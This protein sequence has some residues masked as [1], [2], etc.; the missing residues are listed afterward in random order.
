MRI[1]MREICHR[2]GTLGR[3]AVHDEGGAVIEPTSHALRA[4][5]LI[6]ISRGSVESPIGDREV[7][8]ATDE[9]WLLPRHARELSW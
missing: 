6:K 4:V 3:W 9:T 2:K 5:V 8:G 7:A 1:S